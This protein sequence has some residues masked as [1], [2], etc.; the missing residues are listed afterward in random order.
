MRRSLA[1]GHA[2]GGRRCGTDTPRSAPPRACERTSLTSTPTS[3]RAQLPV[4]EL[5][6]LGRLLA[7]EWLTAA[8]FHIEAHQRLG[9]RAAQVETPLCELHRQAVREVDGPRRALVVR[10]HAGEDRAGI[11]R[12]VPVDLPTRRKEAHALTDERRER[13]SA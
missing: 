5:Q 3:Q 12:K 8:G 10:A 1:T 11:A 7:H 9:V 4:D 13:L 6:H 2:G